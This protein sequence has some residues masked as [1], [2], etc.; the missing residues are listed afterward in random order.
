MTARPLTL[1]QNY[2]ATVRS[3]VELHKLIADGKGDDSEGDEIRDA[4]ANTWA[5]LS[6]TERERARWVSEDLYSLHEKPPARREMTREAQTAL[7]E[8]Y[9]AKM[10]GEWDNALALLRDWQAYF[11]PALVNYLRGSIW[12][13]AGDVMLAGIFFENAHQLDPTN[14]NYSSISLHCLSV[15]DPKR[16]LQEADRILKDYKQH[17]PVLYVRAADIKL[18]S[19]KLLSD[20]EG[21]RVFLSL[22]PV[23]KEA[24]QIAQTDPTK[25]D[26]TTVVMAFGLLGFGYEFQGRLHDAVNHYSMGIHI[27]PDNDGL[28]VARGM[29][30]YGSHG[31][32]IAD[33]EQA[34]GLGSPLIWPFAILAHHALK[35][36]QYKKCIQLCEK[37]LGNKGSPAVKSEIREWEAI[38]Q[39]ALEYSPGSIEQ[40]FEQAA[41]LDA[42]NERAKRNLKKLMNAPRRP[43]AS[44][45]EV[46]SEAE[47]RTSALAERRYA[48]VGT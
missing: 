20:A 35:T 15:A 37:A 26:A 24:V 33:L 14:L 46:R 10:R 45:F 34:I 32:G 17:S 31:V 43:S 38:A 22:E 44:Y 11:D 16:A 39:A 25:I 28:L 12:F 7:N 9:E 30:L 8:A 23:L 5:A 4:S 47:L 2:L 3:T 36:H 41:R 1:S 13:D 40:A 21:N 29:I 6:R 48:M 27:D 19:A 42:A 18:M